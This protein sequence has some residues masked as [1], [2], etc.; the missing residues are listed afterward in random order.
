VSLRLLYLI[1]VRLCDRLVLLARELQA[2]LLALAQHVE[3]AEAA[4]PAGQITW[5]PSVPQPGNGMNPRQAPSHSRMTAGPVP[6]P[7]LERAA[8]RAGRRDVR[9]V[10]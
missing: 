4:G 2:E 10:R 9:Y 7:G 5:P 6:G 3:I 1:F 8:H